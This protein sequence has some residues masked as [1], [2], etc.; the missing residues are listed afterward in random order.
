MLRFVALSLALVAAS[1]GS[2][3]AAGDAENGKKAFRKCVACHKA[4]E[5]AKNGVGPILTTVVGRKAGTVEEYTYSQSNHN[6]GAEGLVWTE[7]NLAAYLPDPSAF[8]EDFLKKKGKPEL[9]IGPTKMSFKLADK[10]AAADIIAYL[11]SL[12]K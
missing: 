9:Y 8:L 5:G 11:K 4:G 3:F 2:A 1:A 6:A 7:E 12:A 10:D